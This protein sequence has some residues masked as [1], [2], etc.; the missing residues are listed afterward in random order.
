M[1]EQELRDGLH[2][3]VESVEVPGD[4]AI[5]AEKGWR[6]RRRTQGVVAGAT[7]AV[8]AVVGAVVVALPRPGPSPVAALPSEGG[9]GCLEL[10]A[11]AAQQ[12]ATGSIPGWRYRG[13]PALK[14]KILALAPANLRATARPLLASRTV[15]E[16]SPNTWVYA[17]ALRQPSGW[18]V[19]IGAGEEH[20]G[21]LLPIEDVTLPLPAAGPVSAFVT[22]SGGLFGGPA[23]GALV[24]LGAPGT[25]RIEYTGCRDGRTFTTGNSGDFLVLTTGALEEAGWLTAQVEGALI[26]LGRPQDVRML[27]L[28]SPGST[29]LSG[30]GDKLAD[31][32]LQL[33][34]FDRTGTAWFGSYSPGPERFRVVV[35]GVCSGRGSA[36]FEG[37]ALPCDGRTHRVWAGS[38][39]FEHDRF[40][41]TGVPDP[42][43][44]RTSVAVALTV[45]AAP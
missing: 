10:P 27:P 11:P 22:L 17:L 2:A 35:L 18:Q 21:Q 34:A 30:Y 9:S 41:V 5:R 20:G 32:Q 15:S 8:L 6:R 29:D 45:V 44:G 31:T 23:G 37:T 19:R 3:E 14:A 39:D 4:L 25:Q 7:L 43:T 13:D 24:V 36:R 28:A 12:P 16:T 33:V 42:A 40:E 26:P 38:L 1:S